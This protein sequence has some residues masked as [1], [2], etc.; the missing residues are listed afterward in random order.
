[1]QLDL[2]GIAVP[3]NLAREYERIDEQKL[4]AAIE[5]LFEALPDRDGARLNLQLERTRSSWLFG[6]LDRDDAELTIRPG[7]FIPEASFRIAAGGPNHDERRLLLINFYVS[8]FP[9]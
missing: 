9:G 4:L 8:T 6:S 2:N 1:V 5:L 3:P 7:E